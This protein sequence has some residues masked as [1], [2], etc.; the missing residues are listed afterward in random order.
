MHRKLTPD[1]SHVATQKLADGWLVTFQYD[2]DRAY[3]VTAVRKIASRW[4]RC[5]AQ[6]ESAAASATARDAC[7][8]LR[9]DATPS[10]RAQPNRVNRRALLGKWSLDDDEMSAVIEFKRGGR[11]TMKVRKHS[12]TRSAVG[13]GTYEWIDDS[14]LRC[15]FVL[16]R[17]P[18]VN[19]LKIVEL[20]KQRLSA[21]DELGTTMTLQRAR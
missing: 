13:S 19:T 2:N 21:V 4:I 6:P 20:T 17:V 10:Q 12:M 9:A 8:S 3:A 5:Y 16:D 11:L 1:M 18:K 15:G 7:L 14:T